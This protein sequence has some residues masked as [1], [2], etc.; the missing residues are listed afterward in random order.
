MNETE[1]LFTEILNCDRLS[2]Y[3]NSSLALDK[4]KSS[5]I[6]SILKR[7]IQGEPIQ[8]ILGKTEFMG[9]EFKLNSDVF[10]PRPETEI[11]V[12]AAIKYALG[13]SASTCRILELGTGSGC[14]AISLAKYSAGAILTAT[15]ISEEALHLAEENARLNNVEDKITF[16][17]SNLFESLPMPGMRYAI[18]VSNPPYL[19]S[20]ALRSLQPEVKYEPAVALDGARD[21]LDFYRRIIS[22]APNYLEEGG[23]LI[24]EMGFNQAKRIEKIFESHK[25]FKI[26]E[27]IKD[28]NKIDRVIVA[29]SK[30]QN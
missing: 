16:F 7:R 12:E 24:M 23:F 10:I 25:R 5:L 26:I 29:Q 2:L 17:R 20:D 9:L 11:L 30:T 8:Y 4:D 3:Q 1:L 21:G 6:A 14:I 28:Y 18:S 22:Q 13:L 27:L 15:D 19:D